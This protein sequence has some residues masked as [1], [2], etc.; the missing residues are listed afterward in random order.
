MSIQATQRGWIETLQEVD[1][2]VAIPGSEA[3]TPFEVNVSSKSSCDRFRRRDEPPV[4]NSTVVNPTVVNPTAAICHYHLH[5]S[6][7]YGSTCNYSHDLNFVQR[8]P[9]SHLLKGTNP[10]TM[11]IKQSSSCLQPAALQLFMLNNHSSHK[12]AGN[13]T[14]T[15]SAA[16]VVAPSIVVDIDTGPLGILPGFYYD[17]QTQKYFKG[18]KPSPIEPVCAPPQEF[19]P[20]IGKNTK[21]L[22]RLLRDEQR[23]SIRLRYPG[24]IT[25]KCLALSN[26]AKIAT[27]SHLGPIVN[28]SIVSATENAQYTYQCYSIHREGIIQKVSFVLDKLQAVSIDTSAVAPIDVVGGMRTIRAHA[29]DPDLV[30]V[31]CLGGA[32]CGWLSASHFGSNPGCTTILYY[33]SRTLL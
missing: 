6:C 14:S 27:T 20:T 22:V 24:V 19:N 26:S 25:S 32:V 12:T 29:D 31:S 30:L 10:A 8:M 1:G 23:S 33:Y 11:Q 2:V 4:V 7:H 17:Q 16:S 3:S 21:H 28:M 15:R 5:R 13:R 18:N 9:A